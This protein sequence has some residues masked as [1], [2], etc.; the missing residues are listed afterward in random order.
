MRTTLDLP[1]NLIKQAMKLTGK[2]T[3]T[4]TII[5]A[6]EELIR[7]NETKKIKN[8]FG[9]LPELDVD[10]DTLRDRKYK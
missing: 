10:I 7:F 4:G 9:K 8:Y 3:K 5:K 1:E 2:K 6:L